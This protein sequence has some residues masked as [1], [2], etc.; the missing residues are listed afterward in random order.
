MTKIKYIYID[1]NIKTNRV[2]STMLVLS[3]LEIE[4][5]ELKIKNIQ[6]QIGT[7]PIDLQEIYLKIIG[8]SSDEFA[9]MW[10]KV[11]IEKKREAFEISMNFFDQL[12]V[13]FLEQKTTLERFSEIVNRLDQDA[14]VYQKKQ[15]Q[16][17]LDAYA[18]YRMRQSQNR[19]LHTQFMKDIKNTIKRVQ[20]IKPPQ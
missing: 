18:R 10:T 7:F 1:D 4:Q 3:D 5:L 17:K 12:L 14:Q 8:Y 9:F 19:Y 15:I 2:V 11:A 20:K 6:L 16:S 13:E